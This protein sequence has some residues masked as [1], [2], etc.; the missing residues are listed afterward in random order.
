[1]WV[2]RELNT[3]DAFVIAAWLPGTE[4][5]GIAEVLFGKTIEEK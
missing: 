3:S 2:N 4:G 1:M 5:H